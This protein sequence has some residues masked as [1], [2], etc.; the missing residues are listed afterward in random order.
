MNNQQ[1]KDWRY[2][3]QENKKAQNISPLIMAIVN[4][5]PDS[6]SDG[7]QFYRFD[8]ACR[9]VDKLL[10]LGVDIIDVGGE[11]SRPGAKPISVEEEL[12][13][14]I[15]VI[16]YIQQ[17]SD[18]CLSIDTTKSVVMEAAIKAGAGFINDITALKDPEALAI[19]KKH[20]IPVCLMHMDGEPLTM[21]NS[22]DNTVCMLE[23][24]H[25]FFQERITVCINNGLK[26][27]QLILDPGFGFGKNVAHNLQIIR[28]IHQFH[29]YG[30]PI[31]LGVSRKST[32]GTIINDSLGNRLI[33][34]IVISIIA[35]LQRVAIIRTHDVK[36][37]QQAVKTLTA[38][39]LA[40]THWG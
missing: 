21:Q 20:Q 4:I 31:M 17:V 35:Q 16:E 23:K 11:S 10:K 5:T 1:F 25:N 14:V 22:L 39:G 24:I 18:I 36:E 29:R 30:C 28:S 38:I 37:T 8:D 9:Y 40:G 26:L 32:L 12:A 34:G 19:V 33:P 27:D 2:Q 13:R 15:P 7:G 6:F 3:Y